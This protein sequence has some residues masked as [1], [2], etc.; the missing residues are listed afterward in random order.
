MRK[1][2]IPRSLFEKIAI[3]YVICPIIVFF[4]GWTKIYIALVASGLLLFS[5]FKVFKRKFLNDEI[6]YI[7]FK[8]CK[9]RRGF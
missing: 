1:I 9:F 3:I 2:C 7:D 5:V 4:F 6:I 8:I